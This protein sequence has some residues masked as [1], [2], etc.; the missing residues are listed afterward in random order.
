MQ[1]SNFDQISQQQQQK[2]K[3]LPPTTALLKM[4]FDEVVEKYVDI[5][6]DGNKKSS[7]TSQMI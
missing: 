7:E 4:L 5:M 2:V 3:E 1:S 6:S